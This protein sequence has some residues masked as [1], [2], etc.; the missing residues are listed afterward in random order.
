MP[1]GDAA[2]E[3]PYLDRQ[4]LAKL[5]QGKP[6]KLEKFAALFKSSARK[7][8]AELDEVLRQED[9]TAI[10]A[11]GHRMKSSARSMGAMSLGALCQSLEQFAQGGDILQAHDI[12]TRLRAE[13]TH[14][15]ELLSRETMQASASA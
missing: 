11:L 8:L 6:E 13:Q 2:D 7:G 5:A 4:V 15:E 14:V 3:E 1:P 9:M 12:V 10:A